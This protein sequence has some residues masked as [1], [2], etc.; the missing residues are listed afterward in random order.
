M[1]RYGDCFFCEAVNPLCSATC[2]VLTF[3][4]LSFLTTAAIE[5]RHRS[6]LKSGLTGEIS[7]WQMNVYE[8]I[9]YAIPDVHAFDI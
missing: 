9:W 4:V 1:V 6:A 7:S 3:R 2:M 5:Q 8:V